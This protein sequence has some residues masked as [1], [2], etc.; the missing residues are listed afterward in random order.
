MK[1]ENLIISFSGGRT[2]AYMTKMLLESND[3]KNIHVIFANTGQEHEKTLDF[4]NNCDK[5]FGFET[6]WVEAEVQEGKGNGTRHSIVSYE[7]A[8]RNGK[9]FEDVIKKYGIPFSKAPNCTRELKLYPIM[10]YVRSLGLRRGEYHMAIGIRVDE[11]DRMSTTAKKDGIIYPLVG[12]NIK[13]IDVLKWWSEQDFDL[14]IPE[15]MGNCVW[16]WKKSFKK[17]VTVMKEDPEAFNFPRRMEREYSRCGAFAKKTGDEVRFFRG[18][19][20]VSDIE[21]MLKEGHATFKDEWFEM[22]NGCSDSCEVFTEDT[23]FEM[24]FD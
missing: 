8:S 4:V 15:H 21:Q 19:R 7:T 22:T 5:Y 23:Q 10:S 17:L 16:C 2:S 14:E 11:I 1:P 12:S 24:D 3:Y 18:R 13:K 20:T 9:P 6:T